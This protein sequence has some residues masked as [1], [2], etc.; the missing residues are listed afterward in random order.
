MPFIQSIETARAERIG[1][2]GVAA[3]TFDDAQRRSG[4]A[5]DQP[6]VE[7]GKVLAKRYLRGG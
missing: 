2:E 7:E 6:A 1:A 4:E 3:A 5:L